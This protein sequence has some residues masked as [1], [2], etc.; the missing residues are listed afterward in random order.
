LWCHL[1]NVED[2][3][4]IKLAD[5]GFATFVTA[6]KSITKRCGTPF[7]VAPEIL[8][9]KPYDESAD[10]WSLG[11]IIYLLIGGTMP[12]VGRTQQ[13]LFH[14]IME[15]KYSFPDE[16]WHNVSPAAKELISNLLQVDPDLRWTAR[17][18]LQC[19]WIQQLSAVELAKHDL[20][21]SARE[22]KF[23]NARLKFKAAIIGV[24]LVQGWQRRR[25]KKDFDKCK[26]SMTMTSRNSLLPLIL[27]SLVRKI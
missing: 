26:H 12:F 18:A 23:F 4:S 9:K 19:T 5:F 24:A 11:I 3:S 6:P 22:L 13:E 25:L 27:V 21:K 7:F 15:G 17:Q 10:M 8:K 1:K 16:Y 14:A 2:D 20:R